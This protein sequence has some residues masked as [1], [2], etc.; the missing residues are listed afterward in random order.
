MGGG[1]IGKRKRVEVARV[2]RRHPKMPASPTEGHIWL[3][4]QGANPCPPNFLG[5]HM[6]REI[7]DD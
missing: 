2:S 6:N 7:K 1:G 3:T 5:D 4:M